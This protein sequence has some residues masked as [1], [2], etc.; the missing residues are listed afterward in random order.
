MNRCVLLGLFTALLC[1][2]C[3]AVAKTDRYALAQGFEKTVV[4]GSGFRHVVYLNR[5]ASESGEALNV[6]IEGDG[7]PWI[8]R[9]FVAKNPTSADTLMLRLMAL[10]P[11]PALYLGRPC[12]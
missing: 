2:G 3:A 7:T 1:A 12:Y 10:D 8:L 4:E 5:R 11:A 6:Y 9:R